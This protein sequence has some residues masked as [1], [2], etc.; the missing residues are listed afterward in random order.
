MHRAVLEI[1]PLAEGDVQIRMYRTGDVVG[2]AGLTVEVRAITA[3]RIELAIAGAPRVLAVG[4]RQTIGTS[5]VAW[6]LR[7]VAIAPPHT[8]PP[9][10]TEHALLAAIRDDPE[11]DEP[12]RIYAD[13]LLAQPAAV[14]QALGELMQLQCADLAPLTPRQRRR[15]RERERALIAAH[16]PPRV[17]AGL[18]LRWA[19]GFVE[20]CRG[21][22]G[23]FAAHARDV[24]AVAPRLSAL[25]LQMTYGLSQLLQVPELAQL[26]ELVLLRADRWGV[27]NIGTLMPALPSLLRLRVNAFVTAGDVKSIVERRAAAQ[28]ELLDLGGNS[29]NEEVIAALVAAAH[30]QPAVLRL[31]RCDVH[32]QRLV[33]LG[34]APWL[35]E[36]VELDLGENPLKSGIGSLAQHSLRRLRRLS[37]A[38]CQLGSV[39]ASGLAGMA[40]LG[41]LTHLRLHSNPFGDAGAI[42]LSRSL[43]AVEDLDLQ[44]CGIGALGVAALVET[45]H[46]RALRR[47]RL[48]GNPIGDAGAHALAAARHLPALAYLDLRN[49]GITD[50]GAAALIDSA[51]PEVALT[52]A[53]LSPQLRTRVRERFGIGEDS[54]DDDDLVAWR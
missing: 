3:E 14:D 31:A 12:R 52:P 7:V 18:E 30:L 19:R 20:R 34:A 17:A 49:C 35:S 22:L 50:D 4:D 1:A 41:R 46:L 33:E 10:D 48:A 15:L 43:R 5:A 36:V 53:E 13:Y 25:E 11:A 26:R 21:A 6:T 9:L 39:A 37:L 44:S 16:P 54:A 29:I 40:A 2:L 51:I 47:W 32:Q 45:P 38:S 23:A 24:F 27:D 28:L 42:A 8:A